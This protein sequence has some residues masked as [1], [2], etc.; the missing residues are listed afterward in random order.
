MPPMP[1][2]I[3]CDPGID[4]ALA[5]LLAA[6]SPELELLGVTCV[7]GNRPVDV[8]SDN[9]CRVLDSPAAATCRCTAAASGPWPTATRA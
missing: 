6:A 9:A 5:L 4:D 8:T 3:D 2:V 1:L 7:A